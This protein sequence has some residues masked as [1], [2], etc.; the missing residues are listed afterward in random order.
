MKGYLQVLLA[1]VLLGQSVQGVQFKPGVEYVYQFTSTHE[2]LPIG[3]LVIQAQ[4]C[5]VAM[6]LC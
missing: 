2:A 3:R 5:V 4:V 1:A 6:T